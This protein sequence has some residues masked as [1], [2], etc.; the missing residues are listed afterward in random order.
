M[1]EEIVTAS[2]AAAAATPRG[3]RRAVAGPD[4]DEALPRVMFD[5]GLRIGEAAAARWDHVTA[6]GDTRY[7]RLLIPRSKTDQ[8]GRGARLRLSPPTMLALAEHLVQRG[9]PEVCSGRPRTV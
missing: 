7:G 3:V 9:P 2:L 6:S 5:A 4:D 8:A 1:L